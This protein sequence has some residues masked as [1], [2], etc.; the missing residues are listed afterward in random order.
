MAQTNLIY[1]ARLVGRVPVLSD[2]VPG[3]MHGNPGF[4]PVSTVFDLPRLAETLR[5]PILEWSDLKLIED[6]K[7]GEWEDIGCWSLHVEIFGKDANS[8]G[9]FQSEHQNKLGM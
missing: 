5:M 2:F 3:H 1:L 7:Q 9:H 6:P 4:L 8:G